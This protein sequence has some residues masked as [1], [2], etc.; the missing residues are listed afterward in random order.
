MNAHEFFCHSLKLVSRVIL[1]IVYLYFL[2]FLLCV[3][4]ILLTF[5]TF[6]LYLGMTVT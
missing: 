6:S 4:V 2:H 5:L 3:P 1:M